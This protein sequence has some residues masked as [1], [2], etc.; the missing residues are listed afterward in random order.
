MQ[1]ILFQ[2]IILASCQETGKIVKTFDSIP[3]EEQC[4]QAC[5][6]SDDCHYYVYKK[7]TKECQLRTKSLSPGDTCDQV[8]VEKGVTGDIAA[9]CKAGKYCIWKLF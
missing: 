6:F 5:G 1:Q 2:G 8:I 7:D 4:Q 9:H 3:S